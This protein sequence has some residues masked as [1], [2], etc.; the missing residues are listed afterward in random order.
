MIRKSKRTDHI[1]GTSSEATI[2]AK[3]EPAWAVPT[4]VVAPKPKK[5]SALPYTAAVEANVANTRKESTPVRAQSA[6]VR[7][8][9]RKGKVAESGTLSSELLVTKTKGSA[10]SDALKQP[11]DKRNAS[12]QVKSL[13]EVEDAIKE[14]ELEYRD[15]RKRTICNCQGMYSICTSSHLLIQISPATSIITGSAKLPELWKNYLP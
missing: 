2:P 5:P 6:P 15:T 8:L 9:P 7:D 11:D 14:L 10:I 12:I 1:S 4:P 13:A 3:K